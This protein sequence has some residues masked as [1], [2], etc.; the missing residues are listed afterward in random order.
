VRFILSNGGGQCISV[1]SYVSFV[2]RSPRQAIARLIAR[3]DSLSDGE[4]LREVSRV[5]ARTDNPLSER[6]AE[7]AAS[8]NSSLDRVSSDH[9]AGQPGF[10]LAD[11]ES[12][13][14]S[15]SSYQM[16]LEEILPR[17][18]LHPERMQEPERWRLG[19]AR[20][21]VIAGQPAFASDDTLITDERPLLYHQVFWV[22]NG[23]A[24]NAIYQG[25]PEN[26]PTFR[27]VV[28]SITFPD[29]VRAAR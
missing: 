12:A 11:L 3:R 13:L 10:V 24:F 6:E 14:R 21:T 20:D 9:F 29:E 28:D 2:E 23:C 7:V 26:L 5:R 8:I 4:F 19:Y 17:I 1:A 16:T 18:R 27:R 22:V 15:A 25:T